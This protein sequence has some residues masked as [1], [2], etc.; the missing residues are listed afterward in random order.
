MTS[1]IR[2]CGCDHCHTQKDIDSFLGGITPT[3][4]MDDVEK[5]DG[6]SS[7]LGIHSAAK[8]LMVDD[9]DYVVVE[10]CDAKMPGS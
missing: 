5:S 4:R 7:P 6:P 2:T 10:D 9:E 8:D 3:H 1:P